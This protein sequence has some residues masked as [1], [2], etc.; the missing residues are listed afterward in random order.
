MDKRGFEELEVKVWK[1]TKKGKREEYTWSWLNK[2]CDWEDE[3]RAWTSISVVSGKNV[4]V[5]GTDS[6]GFESM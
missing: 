1:I 4:A 5:N 6:R 3:V 2:K